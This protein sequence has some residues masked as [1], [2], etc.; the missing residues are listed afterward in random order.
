MLTLAASEPPLVA[1]VSG[2]I[3]DDTKWARDAVAEVLES[4]SWLRPWLFEHTPA[5]TQEVVEGY[6]E[7]V[8]DSDLV[9]WLIEIDTTDAVRNE[10]TTAVNANRPILMFRTAQ[11]ASDPSTESLIKYVGTK[12]D[13]VADGA[14]LKRKLGL[15]LWDE[16]ARAV[17]KAGQS[18]QPALLQAFK[19]RSRARCVER[20][21]ASGVASTTAESLADDPSIGL[22]TVPLFASNRLTILRAEIGAGKSLAAERVYWDAL[23]EAEETGT[24]SPVF[25]E[26]KNIVGPLAEHFHPPG[27]PQ[28][29]NRFRTSRHRRALMRLP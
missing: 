29:F 9:V 18:P 24:D 4:P 7:K 2:R 10:V 14:E 1:F 19:A 11:E 22:L 3:H 20:W 15:A 27:L 21:L 6:L 23:C 26:A 16:V 28:T 8:R 25:L 13:S 17:R 12:W 5:S